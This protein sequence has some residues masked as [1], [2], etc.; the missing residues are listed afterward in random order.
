MKQ[1]HKVGE[2]SS[3]CKW[4]DNFLCVSHLQ[5]WFF[6]NAPRNSLRIHL[7]E[8]YKK[9]LFYLK[10]LK[11]VMKNCTISNLRSNFSNV[12]IQNFRVGDLVHAIRKVAC[13]T[14]RF[15]ALNKV[16]QTLIEAINS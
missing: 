14:F 9:I 3:V 2:N 5:S 10:S 7:F 8:S 4:K 16:H 11:Y 13:R 1:N 6:V 15:L 12:K